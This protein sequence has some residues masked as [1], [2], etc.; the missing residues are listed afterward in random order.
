MGLR[1]LV[2]LVYERRLESSLSPS[3]APRHVGVMCDGN[4]R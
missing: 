2:Y 3:A 1:D 4:R